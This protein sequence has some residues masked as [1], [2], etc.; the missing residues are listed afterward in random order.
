MT[1]YTWFTLDVQSNW[2]HNLELYFIYLFRIEIDNYIFKVH[3]MQ[4]GVPYYEILM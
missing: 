1:G 3:K 4:G 2:K